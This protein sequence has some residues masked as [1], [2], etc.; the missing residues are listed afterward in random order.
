MKRPRISD[1]SAEKR[2]RRGRVLGNVAASIGSLAL[3]LVGV[4]GGMLYDRMPT[5]QTVAWL[6]AVSVPL[7]AALVGVALIL[8][9]WGDHRPLSPRPGWRLYAGVA[10][11]MLVVWTVVRLIGTPYLL[12]GLMGAGILGIAVAVGMLMG[13]AARSP[14]ALAFGIIALVF[15][16]ALLA[17][18]G[19]REYLTEWRGGNPGWRVFAG[20]A[21]PNFLAGLLVTILPLTAV[22]FISVRDRVS[23]IALAFLLALQTLTLLLTQSR[24]GVAALAV[25]IVTLAAAS[26]WSRALIGSTRRRA[27]LMLAL[28]VVVGGVG[29]G[30]V[31]SRLRASRDQSYSARFRV[32]TWEGVQ[33]MIAAR[34][35]I[36]FGTGSF[37]ITYRRHAI[38]GYT[39]HAHNSY[40]QWGS[41]AGA[42]G[43]AL[44]LLT[45]VGS[46]AAGLPALR[47]SE[48]E[49]WPLGDERLVA[50]GL[51]SGLVGA[52]AHNVFDSDLYVPANAVVVGA[53]CGLLAALGR[54]G[55]AAAGQSTPGGAARSAPAWTWNVAVGIG[56][57]ALLV[58]GGVMTLARSW[59]VTGANA[60]ASGDPIRALNAF[61]AAARFNPLD[62]EPYLSMALI[63]DSISEPN[64]ALRALKTSVRIAPFGKTQYRLGRYLLGQG[65]AAAAV[66][67]LEQAKRAD[68]NHLRTLL[69]LA[70]AYQASGRGG[71]ADRIYGAMVELSTTPV[72]LVR[73]VPE[74]VDW[75]YGIAHAAL[76][77]R[78]LSAG[79]DVVAEPR[80][81]DAEAVLGKLW[82]TRKDLMV[83]VRVPADAM[84]EATARY[85]WAL[86][87]RVECLRRLN[88]EAEAPDAEERLAR[89]R[90]ELAG[91]TEDSGSD[92]AP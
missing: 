46:A 92:S 9:A 1:R 68:P 63:Y 6:D 76:A 81:S 86:A 78:A 41:E 48:R 79:R 12:S 35:V 10:A 67:P 56:G 24:L 21:V 13:V 80:L 22:L 36:G 44:L 51:L 66:A 3:L 29:S 28:V 87:Q 38:V 37:D 33:Q 14:R 74:V 4:K 32:M 15:V 40:L 64:E 53:V 7:A 16:G 26:V 77:E 89:F 90:R 18:I 8:W 27:L 19:L 47:A 55:G 61:R 60:L 70:E 34:P 45:L 65:D 30:P 91:D 23:A 58:G 50:A 73:A 2:L 59:T 31:I 84:R 42:V 5:S 75:E 57:V 11:A 88:R 54:R 20:F 39:Q 85:E 82:K 62:P 49:D 43:L 83:R 69:A 17:I 71:E 25:G 72:G 52:M